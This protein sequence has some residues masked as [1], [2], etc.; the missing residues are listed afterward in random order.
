MWY[1]V[2][3]G[4]SKDFGCWG[5]HITTQLGCGMELWVWHLWVAECPSE[6]DER[7]KNEVV[8]VESE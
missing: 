1:F 7:M 8:E 2:G 6:S 5:V 4:V 3:G